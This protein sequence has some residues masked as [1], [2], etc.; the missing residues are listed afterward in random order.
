[1]E[2]WLNLY[3][4]TNNN[5]KLHVRLCLCIGSVTVIVFVSQNLDDRNKQTQ[6]LQTAAVVLI[7]GRKHFVHL[8][9]FT[10]EHL[11]DAPFVLLPAAVCFGLLSILTKKCTVSTNRWVKAKN[12]NWNPIFFTYIYIIFHQH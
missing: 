10:V 3:L 5:W 4:Y 1:M 2:L 8:I 12:K 11:H 6:Y 9:T 7:K